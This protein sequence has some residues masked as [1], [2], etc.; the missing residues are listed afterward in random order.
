MSKIEHVSDTALW[1]AV[2]RGRETERPD[3]LYKDP[4]A[5]KLAGERGVQI[6]KR[7]SSAPFMGWMMALRTIAI[8]ELILDA[9]SQGVK[10]VVNLGAGLDTRPYR[11]EIPGDIEWIEVDF[12]DMI[13]FKASGLEGET[14]LMKLSRVP[15]DLSN[16]DLSQKFYQSL[17]NKPGPVLVIT[18][19]VIPYLDTNVVAN[20]ADD[21]FAVANIRYWIHDFRE[22]GFTAGIPKWWLKRYMKGAP[23]KFEVADWFAF[24]SQHGWNIKNKILLHE[25]A[26][27][28]NRP[29]PSPLGISF[30]KLFMSKKKIEY[31]N[32]SSGYAMLERKN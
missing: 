16:R 20:L 23:F 3:A 4:L 12:P 22:G 19:G 6:A 1:V 29:M 2:H 7:M 13:S 9:I 21:L 30:L 14:P 24:F 17:A 32:R 15:L 11:L 25:E 10:T 18:E 5:L 31:H 28:R 8:D 26:L 27:R